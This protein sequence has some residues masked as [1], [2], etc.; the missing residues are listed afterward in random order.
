MFRHARKGQCEEPAM[1]S[2]G[3]L[4]MGTLTR[5]C[6]VEQVKEGEPVEVNVAGFPSLAVYNVAGSIFV[7]D[8][9]CTHGS[10]LLTEGYQDATT[11][12]CAFHGGAFDI[13]TG[14][15]TALPCQVPL[16]TYPV[17]IDDGWI[18]VVAP[19]GE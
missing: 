15:P 5:L 11:I 16:R 13:R 14:A 17:Q 18:S 4:G 1:D 6:R 7:T 3:T 8:N 9:V 10:A 12:E 2:L 19:P